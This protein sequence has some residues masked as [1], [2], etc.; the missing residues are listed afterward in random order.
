MKI[1]KD[2]VNFIYNSIN[3]DISQSN[4]T[5]WKNIVKSSNNDYTDIFIKVKEKAQ[6]ENNLDIIKFMKDIL[7][8]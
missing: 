1:N 5:F 2:K 7:N 8:K 6:N 4:L 3:R